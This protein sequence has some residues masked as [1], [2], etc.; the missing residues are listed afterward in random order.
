M[1]QEL[2]ACQIVEPSVAAQATV[3]WLHGLGADSSDFVP[4]VS[5]LKLPTH[6]PVR[7]I[8][9]DAPVR[10]ITL[11]G[12]YPMRAWYDIYGLTE[13]SPEDAAGIQESEQAIR[14]LIHRE[15]EKGISADRIILV[16]FSQGGAMA[17]HCGLRYPETLGGIIAL[18]TYLPVSDTVLHQATDV[19]RKTPIFIGHGKHDTLIPEAWGKMARDKLRE[20][21][22]QVEWQSYSAEHSVCT[23]EVGD[24]S[25]WLQKR[26]SE[27]APQSV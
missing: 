24:I 5:E 12:G 19:S 22:Y 7:F 16:G 27:H 20:L 11:N 18:S 13:D 4:I 10:S 6:Y 1:K 17:L 14:E 15:Q 23:E 3:I 8:F 21:G 25:A 26:F 9:P 2:L